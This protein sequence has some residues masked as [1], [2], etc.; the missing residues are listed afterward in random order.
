MRRREFIALLGGAAVG[1]CGVH[2]VNGRT[3]APWCLVSAAQQRR[4]ISFTFLKTARARLQRGPK[5][6][7][8]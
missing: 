5:H 6:P 8:R 3:D 7:H 2:G 4:S 1:R